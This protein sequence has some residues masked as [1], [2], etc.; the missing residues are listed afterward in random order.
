MHPLHA[1]TCAC[2]TCPRA[3][4]RAS[5]CVWHAQ[6]EKEAHLKVE[7]EQVGEAQEALM[8]KA[9]EDAALLKESEAAMGQL[10][11]ALG[12]IREEVRRRTDDHRTHLLIAS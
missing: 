3:P 5:Q 12:P 7:R 1:H 10:R 9:A 8:K 11:D 4:S 6:V 2:C